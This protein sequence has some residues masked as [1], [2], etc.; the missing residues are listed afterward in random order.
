MTDEQPT[1]PLL[2]IVKGDPQPDEVAALVAV[3]SA[4]AAGAAEAA[5]RDKRPKPEWAAHHRKLRATP[6][7]GAGAWRNSAR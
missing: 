1:P 5:G 4:L 6:R 7:H 2:R 3:V